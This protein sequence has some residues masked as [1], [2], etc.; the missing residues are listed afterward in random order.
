M[1]LVLLVLAAERIWTGTRKGASRS[2]GLDNPFTQILLTL[3]LAKLCRVP[4]ITDDLLSPQLQRLTGVANLL[5]LAGMTFGALSAIPVLAFSS[6]ITGRNLSARIQ[7]VAAGVVVM[8]MVG[9]YLPSPMAREAVPFLQNHFAVTGAV[10]PYWIAFIA[11]L[12]LS[13][14]VGFAYTV[15]ELVWVRRGPF[16]RALAGV[17]VAYLLGFAYCAFNVANLVGNYTGTDSFVVRNSEIIENSLGLASL[18]AAGFSAATYAWHILRDRARRYRLLRRH[19][20]T[21]LEARKV[22]PEVVLDKSYH[23]RPTRRACWSAARS[24]QAAYRLQME[25]ADHKHQAA[26]QLRVLR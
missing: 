26:R 15:R 14:L 23:F 20:R 19:G 1:P 5:T 24:A 11:P 2:T 9:T 18:A 7:V 10:L 21:W 8:V 16:A 4:Y 3:G 25:L 22:S 13:T 6:Y 17:V 12:T